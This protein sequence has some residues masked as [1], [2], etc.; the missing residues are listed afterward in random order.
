VQDCL[1]FSHCLTRAKANTDHCLSQKHLRRGYDQPFSTIVGSL[2]KH[3]RLHL[4]P[5][6]GTERLLSIA[7]RKRL[8]SMPD[9]LALRVSRC[10]PQS[11]L[12]PN[13]KP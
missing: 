3:A 6:P 4:C 2:S 9:R 5:R 10:P 13:H 12:N 1:V 7:E 11:N 8:Q